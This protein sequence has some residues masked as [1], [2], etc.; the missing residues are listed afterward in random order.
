MSMSDV[1]RRRG[2]AAQ[3]A[4]AVRVM[5]FFLDRGA[6]PE[7]QREIL[8]IEEEN[9]GSLDRLV[10]GLIQ[11]GQ[12]ALY[13]LAD[14]ANITHLQALERLVSLQ[15]MHGEGLIDLPTADDR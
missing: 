13:P 9:D 4:L 8:D 1:E 2:Q 7:L 6:G 14:S 10:L 15:A 5:T 11:L 12:R 3:V